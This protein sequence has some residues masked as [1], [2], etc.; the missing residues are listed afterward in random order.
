M[1]LLKKWM[2]TWFCLVELKVKRLFL[3]QEMG[4]QDDLWSFF[5]MMA[6]FANGH[7]PWRKMKDKVHNKHVDILHVP[8]QTLTFTLLFGRHHQVRE[9]AMG[10]T[11]MFLS[12]VNVFC[13][14][15][16]NTLT[17][18]WNLFVL[19]GNKAKC[20]EWWHLYASVLQCVCHSAN[21]TNNDENIVQEQVG[22]MKKSY[23]H[24][25]FLKS[26][27]LGFKQFLDHIYKLKYEDK[28][29]YKVKEQASIWFEL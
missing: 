27:P 4:R 5:Y 20:C 11:P 17:A 25:L 10:W 2:V 6:E 26:L 14:L 13:D 1:I 22:K 3:W 15:L 9:T 8:I 23:D 7:L 16:L 28:P 24:Q 18:T 12:H 29:D 21:H 19:F